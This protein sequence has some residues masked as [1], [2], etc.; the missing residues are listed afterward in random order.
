MRTALLIL[1]LMA[2]TAATGCVFS[3]EYKSTPQE[4]RDPQPAGL[5]VRL[6]ENPDARS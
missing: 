5:D 3:H 2:A 1:G 6:A 4:R